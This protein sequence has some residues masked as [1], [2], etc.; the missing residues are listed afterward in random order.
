[1][2]DLNYTR[3][4]RDELDKSFESFFDTFNRSP[5]KLK[6]IMDTAVRGELKK[7]ALNILSG[8]TL[9]EEDTKHF[10]QLALGELEDIIE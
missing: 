9:T 6:I 3:T 4:S 7:R 5:Y 8:T 1:M 2:F 10:G